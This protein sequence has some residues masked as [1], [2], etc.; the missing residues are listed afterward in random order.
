MTT[1]NELPWPGKINITL[2]PSIFN[3]VGTEMQMFVLMYVLRL[4]H[5]QALFSA[6]YCV[7]CSSGWIL[8]IQSI[9]YFHN[10][11]LSTRMNA[12]NFQA[13]RIPGHPICVHMQLPTYFYLIHPTKN[14]CIAS[15]L[16]V[17]LFSL[18]LLFICPSFCPHQSLSKKGWLF[19]AHSIL[20]INTS[21]TFKCILLLL[22]SV[23]MI[24]YAVLNKHC[25]FVVCLCLM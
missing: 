24:I 4:Q 9:N 14:G 20:H 15:L 12:N 2:L 16:I 1:Q 5:L 18:S 8:I 25:E 13:R 6:C 7:C 3:S 11:F 10:F 22:C 23:F 21:H 17:V 19:V